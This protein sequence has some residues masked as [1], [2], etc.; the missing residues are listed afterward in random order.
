M[1]DMPTSCR[2]GDSISWSVSFPDYPASDWTLTYTFLHD[3]LPKW[4]VTASADGPSFRVTIPAAT[5]ATYAP[6]TYYFVAGVSNG[7]EQLTVD[8]GYVTVLPNPATATTLDARSHAQKMLA[9]IEATLEG[10]ATSTE[11]EVELQGRRVR[12]YTPEELI[13]WHS[14]YRMLVLSEQRAYAVSR[15]MG[16]KAK[17][18]VR[19]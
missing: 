16:T 8:A 1:A 11:L 2:A 19:L 13:K 17:V 12:Y 18:L 4:T 9:I 5:S 6:G 14:H 15:G 3:T 10:R 7:S